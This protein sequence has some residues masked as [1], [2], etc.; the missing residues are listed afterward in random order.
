M[1]RPRLFTRAKVSFLRRMVSAKPFAKTVKSSSKGRRHVS[2]SMR[3]RRS[4]F[5]FAFAERLGRRPRRAVASGSRSFLTNT[6][7]TTSPSSHKTQK[8]RKTQPIKHRYHRPHL[9]PQPR[10][11]LS[12]GNPRRQRLLRHLRHLLQQRIQLTL[13]PS[14]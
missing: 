5:F 9:H 2:V 13:P 3:R 10:H 11:P 4:H 1:L 12:H 6:H 7:N 8:N 14:Q